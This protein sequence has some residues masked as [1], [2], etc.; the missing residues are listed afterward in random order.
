MEEDT[1]K[2]KSIL[3][4]LVLVVTVLLLGLLAWQFTANT[5]TSAQVEAEN[6]NPTSVTDDSNRSEM[7][8]L[9]QGQQQSIP[10]FG[11]ALSLES[12]NLTPCNEGS[13]ETDGMPD[14]CSLRRGQVTVGVF[15]IQGLNNDIPT[16]D[17]PPAAPERII[18]P[19]VPGTQPSQHLILQIVEYKDG[20]AQILVRKKDNLVPTQ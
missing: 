2:S 6:A 17:A 3:G 13:E 1:K 5:D 19:T 9:H 15:P 10:E 20:A 7:V 8:V 18:F 11:V 12:V 14:D 4:A 16:S